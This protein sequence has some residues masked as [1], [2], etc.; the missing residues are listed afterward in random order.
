MWPKTNLER[1][2]YF[3]STKKKKNPQKT[4]NNQNKPKQ[5]TTTQQINKSHQGVK[6]RLRAQC[7][8]A[9]EETGIREAAVDRIKHT[10]DE[11]CV[12]DRELHRKSPLDQGFI[13]FSH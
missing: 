4:N 11:A 9:R 1:K 3:H 5:T 2:M 12:R 10:V 7:S 6:A 8:S 13:S